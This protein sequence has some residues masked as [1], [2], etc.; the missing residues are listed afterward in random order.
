[1]VLGGALLCSGILVASPI[2]VN[3]DTPAL[4]CIYSNFGNPQSFS[5]TNGLVVGF[6]GGAVADSFTPAE[7]FILDNLEVAVILPTEGDSARFSIFDTVDGL[8]GNNILESFTFTGPNDSSGIFT[9]ASVLH[10]VLSA[11]EEYWIVMDAVTN[12]ATWNSAGT[13]TPGVAA[14]ALNDIDP[15]SWVSRDGV[16]QGGVALDGSAVPEPA[17][18]FLS[19]GSLTGLLVLLSRRQRLLH[20]IWVSGASDPS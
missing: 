5:A 8:P 12:N 16:S 7:S 2:C 11:G 9:S 6:T 19:G 17:S 15:P 10:P 1:M 20:I 4:G 14:L 13:F 3:P 18:L